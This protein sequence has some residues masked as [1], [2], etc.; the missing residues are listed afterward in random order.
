VAFP[1]GAGDA[2]S[3]VDHL[4]AELGEGPDRVVVAH[5]LGAT[6]VAM[7]APRLHAEK[8]V[9]LGPVLGLL[10]ERGHGRWWFDP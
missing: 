8:L 2:A 10:P 3:F 1:C 7:A 5:G 4:A 9:F 6:L